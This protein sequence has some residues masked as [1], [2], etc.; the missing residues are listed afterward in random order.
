V[1]LPAELG[2][3]RVDVIAQRANQPCPVPDCPDKHNMLI[4]C[5]ESDDGSMLAVVE[6]PVN[7]F[8]WCD[9]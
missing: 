6:C 7:G 9:L 8:L 3:Q 1:Q 5:G 2:G 4:L